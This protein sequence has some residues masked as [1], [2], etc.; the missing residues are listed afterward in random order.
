MPSSKNFEVKKNRAPNYYVG[1]GASAGGL[2]AIESFFSNMSPTS[3]LTFIVI[4][5][6]SPDY[7]SLMVELLSKRTELKVQK[8]QDGLKLEADNVYLIPP[9]KNLTIFHGK[10]LLSEQ[11]Q[12]KGLNL[13]IDIFFRSLAEDQGD[14]AIGIILSGSGSDGMR[15]V[16]AIKENGGIV[17]VQDEE[18]AKFDGMPRSAIST[19]LPDYILPPQEMPKQLLSYIKH[20]YSAKPKPKSQ[21]LTDEDNLTRIFSL[22]REK[23]KIDFTAYKLNTVIRRI[24]RRMSINQVNELKEYVRFIENTISELS[25]LYH[26]LLIGV[27]NFF[28]DKEAFRILESRYLT[29]LIKSKDSKNLRFWVAGCSSGEE[30]YSVAM[31]VNEALEKLDERK[32]VKIFATDVDENAIIRAGSGIYPESI[33]ADISPEF[34]SKYF[35]KVDDN[36]QVKRELREMVVF[37]HHNLLKDPPF[38]NID[39]ISCRNLLIYIQT[40]YQRKVLNLFNFSLNPGGILFLGSSETIGDMH[41]YFESLEKK[42]QIFK[43][44][45]TR[46]HPT[47][48]HLNVENLRPKER[49]LKLPKLG[50]TKHLHDLREEKMLERLFNS[51]HGDYLPLVLVVN[52]NNEILHILG[53]ASEFLRFPTGKVHYDITKMTPKEISIPIATGLQKSFKGKTS[54]KYSNIKIREN[55]ATKKYNIEIKPIVSKQGQPQL[56]AILID[57]LKPVKDSNGDQNGTTYDIE[58]EAEQR[59]N[60]LEQ[61]LQFTRENLQATIEELETSNEELQATNEELVASNEE[62]QSTNEE[63]QSVNEEL[64]TVNS[65]HQLRIMELTE[66]NNDM[67]NLLDTTNI[68]TLFFDENLDLRKVS[69]RVTDIWGIREKDIGKNISELSKKID[70]FD[71]LKMIT[72]VHKNEESHEEE[73]L[74]DDNKW[75]VVK[76]TPYHITERTI[77]GILVTLIEISKAKQTY[78]SLQ[79]HERW[80]SI[81]SHTA[82]LGYWEFDLQKNM[83]VWS[84]EIFRIHD[85]PL[86]DTPNVHTGIN[87]YIDEHIPVIENAFKDLRNKGKEYDLVLKIKTAKEKLKWVRTIGKAK[88][89]G[90]EIVKVYGSFQDISF[91]KEKENRLNQMEELYHELSDSR[92]NAV[93]TIKKISGRDIIIE[94]I[95]KNAAKLFELKRSETIGKKLNSIFKSSS[96]NSLLSIVREVDK[97]NSPLKID[98][99]KYEIGEKTFELYS[100]IFKL[101]SDE[102][103]VVFDSRKH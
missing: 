79:M 57:E 70:D 36:F 88:K 78:N 60:D 53:D 35:T 83:H 80:T 101:P 32:D 43:S 73:F 94:D 75:F 50:D 28:R 39:F 58:H 30:A 63:L 19:G 45:G 66:A 12:S 48:I 71:F 1:I 68:G 49:E 22:I 65:E 37:A 8:A 10:L 67:I 62:L 77:A 20:P 54:T 4:Q 27:T 90:S 81:A 5:H 9:K 69:S 56:S 51:L 72:T 14:K 6:L 13:P 74:Q 59:I 17:M 24:E 25:V 97:H 46:R 95:N 29:E 15:G 34:L 85:L 96:K 82:K 91:I 100:F 47:D 76:V 87:Y 33:A 21:L 42:W 93:I 7:K 61:E 64:H 55:G 16:R 103:A 102:I 86:E 40:V 99:T 26:E 89:S 98:K 2:E 41:E 11:D 52:E 31:L 3:G 38:T 44:R 84:E 18:S 23:H 92:M